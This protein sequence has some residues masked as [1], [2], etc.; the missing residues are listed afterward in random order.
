MDFDHKDMQHGQFLTLS[1]ARSVGVAT[2]TFARMITSRAVSIFEAKV[3]VSLSK[4][5]RE[6]LSSAVT[7]E[8]TACK[9]DQYLCCTQHL[10]M[11]II[12]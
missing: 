11:F 6:G 7:F 9:I 1:A 10:Q 5:V 8:W 2:A 3:V 4:A 12:S